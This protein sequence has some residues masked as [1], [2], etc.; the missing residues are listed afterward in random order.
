MFDK[1]SLHQ[2]QRK[3]KLGLIFD[4]IKYPDN[5]YKSNKYRDIS[6]LMQNFSQYPLSNSCNVVTAQARRMTSLLGWMA[7][8]TKQH[9]RSV[10]HGKSAT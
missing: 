8:F 5:Q 4:V 3:V 10:L 7:P 9:C 6:R 1:V 2:T